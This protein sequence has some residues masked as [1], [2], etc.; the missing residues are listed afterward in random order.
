MNKIKEIFLK[1]IKLNSTPRGIASGVAIGAFIGVLPLYGLHTVLVVIAAVLIPR[2]NKVAILLGTN[3]S[4]PPTVP[5]ITWSGYEIG[6]FVLPKS[7]PSLAEAYFKQHIT[8]ETIKS[9]YYPLFVGSLILGLIC[10]TILY[11][12]ILIIITRF[13]HKK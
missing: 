2:T 9:I 8:I 12:I 4:L 11:F 3:I 6:R 1:L 5:L 7:Y 10:A 13:K